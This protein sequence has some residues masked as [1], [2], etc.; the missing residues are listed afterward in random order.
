MNI[1][2]K[3]QLGWATNYIIWCQLYQLFGVSG[4]RFFLVFLLLLKC[5]L[6]LLYAFLG[7]QEKNS[8]GGVLALV[9]TCVCP[10]SQSKQTVPLSAKLVP[11][12]QDVYT[13][14][15]ITRI[16]TYKCNQ[17]D[18]AYIETGHFENVEFLIRNCKAELNFAEQSR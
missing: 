5:L 11:G 18:Y 9:F 7:E 12:H 2:N 1:R 6:L 13:D 16:F 4:V 8:N 3:N 17:F 10:P 15:Q 14:A